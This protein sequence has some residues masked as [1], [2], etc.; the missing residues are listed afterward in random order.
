MLDRT[1]STRTN[2][3]LCAGLTWRLHR[4]IL[5]EMSACLW[6]VDIGSGS[7]GTR[8]IRA[9][10]VRRGARPPCPACAGQ[11]HQTRAGPVATGSGPG[12]RPRGR[13]PRAGSGPAQPQWPPDGSPR[14][15]PPTSPPGSARCR[16]PLA[17]PIPRRPCAT[18]GHATTS[19]D[20][21]TTSWP[22]TWRQGHD[23]GRKRPQPP[24]RADERYCSGGVSSLS[25][26]SRTCGDR[27]PCNLRSDGMR[28][29]QVA[30]GGFSL[31]RLAR[32]RDLLERHVDS[33]FVPGDGGR[34]RPPRRGAHRSNGQSRVRGRRV[35]D[36]DGRRHD[37][38]PGL[39]D[40]A[41]RRRVCDDARRGLHPPPR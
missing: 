38:S 25:I 18:T 27:A 32:V 31:R 16:S 2:V 11:R 1:R 37:L 34:P 5:A 17:T 40:E 3:L 30:T 4:P 12:D 7:R 29:R 39:D 14:R 21:P 19:T 33:G 8:G 13:R 26:A 23:H 35:E 24:A 15:H 41:D 20:T 28:R 9:G 10:C 22:P 36:A 6:R